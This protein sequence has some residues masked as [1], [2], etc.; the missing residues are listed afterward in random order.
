MPIKVDRAVRFT[1]R[2]P[3]TFDVL[4]PLTGQALEHVQ[5]NQGQTYT[6]TPRGAA[7][8]VGRFN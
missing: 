7:V 5:I 3:M 2:R 8:F 6:L 4:E 1:A